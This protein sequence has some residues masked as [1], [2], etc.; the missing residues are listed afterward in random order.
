MHLSVSYC[1][2]KRQKSKHKCLTNHCEHIES[3]AR[4]LCL[5][6]FGTTI[7]KKMNMNI[8]MATVLII[9]PKSVL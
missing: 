7:V 1:L 4:A 5:R 3:I 8:S 9:T 2:T 6:K